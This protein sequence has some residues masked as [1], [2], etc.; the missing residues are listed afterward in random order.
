MKNRLFSALFCLILLGCLTLAGAA[1]A[2]QTVNL[3]ES[4]WSLLLPDGMT[5][6]PPLEGED[7]LFA[8]VSDTLEM[9][10]FRYPAGKATLREMAEQLVSAG[11]EAELRNV[12]GVEMLCYR[13]VDTSLDQ[14]PCIGYAMREGES[15]IEICFWYATQEAGDLTEQIISSISQR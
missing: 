14:A 1:L 8:W 6:D 13:A 4:S 5:Y 11:Q 7:C 3:P 9:D 2:D 15:I 12:S 10:V